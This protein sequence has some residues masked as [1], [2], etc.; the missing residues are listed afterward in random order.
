MCQVWCSPIQGLYAQLKGLDPL[1]DIGVD[2]SN[3]NSS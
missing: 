2:L 3:L 1:A